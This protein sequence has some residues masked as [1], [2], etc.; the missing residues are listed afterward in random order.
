MYRHRHPPYTM[1]TTYSHCHGSLQKS[2]LES[3]TC[4]L[5]PG[6][7]GFEIIESSPQTTA[8][9]GNEGGHYC[10]ALAPPLELE[11]EGPD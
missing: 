4:G 6:Y 9:P 10:A 5:V 1:I 8:V 7:D 2:L 11:V 3:N